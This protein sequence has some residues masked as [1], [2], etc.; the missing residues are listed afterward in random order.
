[1]KKVILT[2]FISIV[3]FSCKKSTDNNVAQPTSEKI[4]LDVA[5]ATSSPQQKMDVYLPA[6]RSSTITFPVIMIHGGS[7][8]GGDKADFN[9]DILTLKTLLGRDYAIFNINYRLANGTTVLIPQQISDIDAAMA[10]IN[11]NAAT[12]NI[13][14]NKF[15]VMGASAGGHLAL[16]KSY[17]SNSDNKIKVVV[18]LFGPTDMTWMYN[19]HP[20]PTLTQPIIVN[21]VSGTPTSNATGYTNASPINF[22]IAT[23]PPTIIFHGTIDPIVPISE[24]DR[25]QARLQAAGVIRQYIVYTGESHGWGG[26]N[27]ADTYNKA[28]TFIKNNLQ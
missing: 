17:R 27:L 11:S 22:V 18:D 3:F 21:A 20:I 24:S 26:T 5:Y 15:G 16:L 10:F 25:L 9:N 8:S 4:E 14:T 6:N 19:N 1:M 28:V 13:N 7:W 23:A 12:Y 2:I